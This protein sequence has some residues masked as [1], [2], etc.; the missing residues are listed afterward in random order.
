M[1]LPLHRQGWAGLK[2]LQEIEF[3]LALLDSE[4]CVSEIYTSFIPPTPVGP[5][6]N[7]VMNTQSQSFLIIYLMIKMFF[8]GLYPAFIPIWNSYSMLLPVSV[9][10]KL[11]D[12]H[13]CLLASGP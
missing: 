2:S 7:L 11:N 6:P 10:C 12:D 8:P 1:F 13:V 9:I 3:L 5:D 4:Y